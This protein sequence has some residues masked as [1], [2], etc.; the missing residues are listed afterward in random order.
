MLLSWYVAEFDSYNR[1]YHHWALLLVMTSIWF[2]VVVVLVGAEPNA[3]M[4]LQQ[5]LTGPQVE[6]KPL[7]RRGGSRSSGDRS[8][9]AS[10]R[11]WRSI[12]AMRSCCCEFSAMILT[13]A[14]TRG[15]R[16]KHC[17][18]WPPPDVMPQL[19]NSST[20]T[21]VGADKLTA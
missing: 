16:A 10:S 4:E 21:A 6:P 19:V 15:K 20:L 18:A 12:R 13:A 5:P 17:H 14:R 3:E 1:V 7:G 9:P 11:I 2:S 8:R